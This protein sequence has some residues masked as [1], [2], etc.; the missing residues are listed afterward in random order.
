MGGM[1]SAS[2]ADDEDFGSF[3]H[4]SARHR[5]GAEEIWARMRELAHLPRSERHGGFYVVTR[6][7]D[8]RA[9]AAQHRVYSSAR[10]IALPDEDRSPHV[11]AEV[12]P[13]LQR[14]YRRLLEPFLTPE[15]VARHEPALRRIAA[16]LLDGFASERRVDIVARFAE[17]YP[18]YA[19]LAL[20]GFPREDAARLKGLIT[21]LTHCRGSERSRNASRELTDYLVR[22]LSERAACGDDRDIIAAIGRGSVVGQPLTCEEQVAMTRLLLFGGFT[23]V[24]LA[25]SWTLHLLAR[26][27]E[28]AE[29]LYAEPSLYPT[30]I[31][32]F[33][34]L[35]SP[36][37]YLRRTV[38]CETEL[39]G[40]RLSPGDK[41]LMCFASANRDPEVFHQAE[42]AILDRSP[43]PHLGFGFGAHRCM[44]YAVA[45]LE[46]KVALEEI[47]GR[48]ARLELDTDGAIEWGPGETQGITAL[49]LILHPRAA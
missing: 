49:P 12:D 7:A 24:Y 38:V 33:V 45:K 35:A 2:P 11:P 28:L 6:H 4:H 15:A 31:E 23:T 30:A 48:Y 9:V 16:E 32:E 13:P 29:R 47:L 8:V 18:V 42:E 37:T 40:T 20:F 46:M 17:P 25:L 43:N 14:E 26:Q 19:A 39:G 41:V 27:P 3:D 22:L 44:G 34:R 10:G 36:A 21:A 5:K 1:R